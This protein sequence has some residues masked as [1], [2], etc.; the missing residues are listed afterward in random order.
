M[1]EFRH[2]GRPKLSILST[3]S[4]TVSKVF[5]ACPGVPDTRYFCR[6]LFKSGSV[7]SGASLPF[8]VPVPLSIVLE[9]TPLYFV[10]HL[11]GSTR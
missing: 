8:F 7:G 3:G 4:R 2:S 9:T 5:Q 6:R 10:F 1:V 11:S